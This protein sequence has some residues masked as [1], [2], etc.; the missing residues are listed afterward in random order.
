MP[1]SVVTI[2]VSGCHFSCFFFTKSINERAR[3]CRRHKKLKNIPRLF[4]SKTYLRRLIHRKD[5]QK[6]SLTSTIASI[7]KSFFGQ[8]PA[9]HAHVPLNSDVCFAR[10]IIAYLPA[11]TVTQ[12]LFYGEF[13]QSAREVLIQCGLTYIALRISGKTDFTSIHRC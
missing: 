4:R 13:K 12:I 9:F 10:R 3:F 7:S 6:N 2:V 11:M 8:I 5:S 1:R